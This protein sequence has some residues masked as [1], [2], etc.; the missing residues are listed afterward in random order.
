M[1]LQFSWPRSPWQRESGLNTS[2]A[3]EHVAKF[4][5]SYGIDMW[6]PAQHPCSPAHPLERSAGNAGAT[7]RLE[8]ASSDDTMAARENHIWPYLQP[9]E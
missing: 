5:R 9:P 8:Q 2:A 7:G 4:H 3:S 6:L 1:G